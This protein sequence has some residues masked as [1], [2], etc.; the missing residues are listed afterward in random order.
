MP[1]TNNRIIKTEEQYDQALERIDSLMMDDPA[2]NSDAGR[3]LELLAMLVEQYED[4]VYPVDLPS[5]NAVD[6]FRI[7]QAG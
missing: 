4:L 3:E 5:T 6:R 7:D 1:S 2:A